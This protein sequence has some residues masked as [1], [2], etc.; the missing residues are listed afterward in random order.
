MSGVVPECMEAIDGFKTP[1]K[2][3]NKQTILVKDHMNVPMTVKH[4]L[5]SNS[6]ALLILKLGYS[7]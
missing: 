1:G 2:W 7:H 6:L 3:I 5:D 4:S